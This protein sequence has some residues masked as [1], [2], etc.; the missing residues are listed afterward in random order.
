MI[1]S[2]LYPQDSACCSYSHVSCEHHGTKPAA[3]APASAQAAQDPSS[4][5]H[6]CPNSPFLGSGAAHGTAAATQQKAPVCPVGT[7]FAKPTTVLTS[8]GC[9][10]ILAGKVGN[11]SFLPV[12]QEG[13]RFY[14]QNIK[15]CF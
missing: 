10:R 4:P 8:A 12:G 2:F 6:R 15:L 3:A 5:G 11:N 9:S 14:P 7:W 1:N 13:V